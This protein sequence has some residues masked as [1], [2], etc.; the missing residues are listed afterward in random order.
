[1]TLTERLTQA[2]FYLRT[3]HNASL[4]LKLHYLGHLEKT[5]SREFVFICHLGE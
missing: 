3:R 5:P 1:M 4:T 2:H